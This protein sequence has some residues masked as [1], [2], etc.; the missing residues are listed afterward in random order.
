MAYRECF[1]Y[2]KTTN[3]PACKQE[4][5]MLSN[6]QKMAVELTVG[7]CNMGS[8]SKAAMSILHRAPYTFLNG[9][10]KWVGLTM[11]V[12]EE[13]KVLRNQYTHK[14][15]HY[16]WEHSAL[17]S[18]ASSYEFF[19]GLVTIMK[20]ASCWNCFFTACICNNMNSSCTFGSDLYVRGEGS[21]KEVL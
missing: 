7:T 5:W 1:V 2:N 16:K 19:F 13:P 15:I 21:G 20:I 17:C 9:D 12:I 8:T 10:V 6:F 14:N 11:R 18:A 4:K 3:D